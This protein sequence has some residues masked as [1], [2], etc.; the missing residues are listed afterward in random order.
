[1]KKL[2]LLAIFVCCAS[3]IAQ[4]TISAV[5]V[6]A[7]T[8]TT[9]TIVWT[10]NTPSTSQ[11]RYGYDNTLPFSNNTN[12]ALVTSHSMTLTLLNASQ[13]YY[14]AVVSVSGG[15]SAQSPT[16]QFALCGQG[17]SPVT[18]TV[19]LYY[20]YGTATLT[21][22]PPAGAIGSPT[23][24]GQPVQ[25]PTTVTLGE[26][27]S[28]STTAAD[29]YK[30][31]PG[32][33]TWTVAVVDVG[34]LA[35]ISV[36]VPLSVENQDVSVQLQAAAATSGLTF[37]YGNTITHSLYPSI[38]PF[39]LPVNNPT[40]T[41]TLTGPSIIDSGIAAGSSPICPNGPGGAF[42]TTGCTPAAGAVTA[43]SVATANGLEGS[44]GGGTTPILTLNVDATH[45]LPTTTDESN[46]NGKQTAY[47]N[48]TTLGNLAN[49]SGWLH[50]DGAGVLAYS[51]PPGL[52]TTTYSLTMDN[53]GLGDASGATFDG[54]AARKISYNSISAARDPAIVGG[55]Q[56]CPGVVNGDA[57][58]STANQAAL[59]A[60]INTGG[61]YILPNNCQGSLGDI[62]IDSA[63]S[64]PVKGVQIRGSGY[65]IYS[66]C[67]TTIKVLSTTSDGFDIGGLGN[68][69]IP[70]IDLENLTVFFPNGTTGVGI[71]GAPIYGTVYSATPT[72][73]LGDIVISSN[74]WWVSLQ[75]GNHAHTPT[76]GAWWALTPLNNTS[77]AIYPATY[78]AGSTYAAGDEVGYLGNLWISLQG[79]NHGNTPA[80]GAYWAQAGYDYGGDYIETHDVQIS[81]ARQALVA[82]G[83][84]NGRIHEL[85][86]AGNVAASNGYYM[87]ELGPNYTNSWEL[88]IGDISCM[89][90]TSVGS[91]TA[92]GALRILNG[93][94]NVA[95]IG[96]I[97]LCHN[98]LEVGNTTYA[99]TVDAF[100]LNV[101]SITGAI[102]IANP[103]TQVAVHF[104]GGNGTYYN[105]TSS[106]FQ[107]NGASMTIYN[108][109]AY[110]SGTPYPLVTKGSYH[111][112][113]SVINPRCAD[114][115]AATL[116][117]LAQ[118]VAGEQYYASDT[119]M[120]LSDAQT[121]LTPSAYTRLRCYKVAT[122]AATAGYDR[123]YC[124][125]R[126]PAG[127]YFH[128]PNWLTSADTQGVNY[129][130]TGSVID[131]TATG[132]GAFGIINANGLYDTALLNNTSTGTTATYAACV[133]TTTA[134]S[135]VDCP[136][137]AVQ[138]VL[139]ITVSGAGTTGYPKILRLAQTTSAT[140]VGSTTSAIGNYATTSSAIGK[141]LD[142]ASTTRPTCGNAIVGIITAANTGTTHTI[143]V[144][145]EALPACGTTGQVMQATSN[146]ALGM[147]AVPVP[148]AIPAAN[149]TAGALTNGMTATTQAAGDGTADVATD[150]F[151][152]GNTEAP[153][154]QGFYENFG[155]TG[156]NAFGARGNGYTICTSATPTSVNETA[157]A[158]ALMNAASAATTGS[159]AGWYGQTG[160]WTTKFPFYTWGFDFS[161]AGDYANDRVMLGFLQAGANY[162]TFNASDRPA[163]NYAG[164]RWRTGLSDTTWMCVTAT[165]ASNYTETAIGVTAPSTTYTVMSAYWN[166]DSS[167]FTCCVGATCVK[168]TTH[169]PS[170]SLAYFPVFF[171]ATTTNTAINL[172]LSGG[173]GCS[174]TTAAC[175]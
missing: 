1:M 148:A 83:Y 165:D 58:Y 125:G 52:G 143:L 59:Q 49:S 79:S 72:Y 23:V 134:G 44:S 136:A 150:A 97:G 106:P 132:V 116:G 27:G 45:Y 71:F 62:Y 171:N 55:W 142:T 158:P 40:F 19:N 166:T 17:I 8:S 140:F 25:T 77:T 104:Q 18:G 108:P 128:G 111:D 119:M 73:G 152:V 109:P 87:I 7:S 54:S 172:Q 30:V 101:E 76:A 133:D 12:P 131:P 47:T 102:A 95:H 24:C 121:P 112:I 135:A 81:N 117:C 36:T 160:R 168:N 141:L 100:I 85:S 157:T 41:G 32:P 96:D 174:Q 64:I 46:W 173:R 90:A 29:S 34:D 48:L 129:F 164:I 82:Y 167:G 56:P 70:A 110:V 75:A 13:P 103:N 105:T 80:A 69:L 60:C 28:F 91:I 21:W 113:L 147:A 88:D 123:I 5:Y 74:Q 26:M 124:D 159:C 146:T 53:S 130:P 169:L 151:V 3:A 127:V 114:N 78:S 154:G 4:P 51:T 175:H 145:P 10:T 20:G 153:W 98:I 115:N 86:A 170:A 11:I 50:N 149:I 37:F 6:S 61:K 92:G 107:M 57:T 2:V 39:G 65:G 89:P 15:H 161:A 35:P 126:N 99:A 155:Q 84:G 63:L 16:Y 163:Y 42:T 67:S 138:Q 122:R 43:V 38:V 144:R 33:G 9:A 14:F 156:V 162:S 66:L 120:E 93:I 137:N 68:W 94:G 118:D 31:T 22:V 139:G